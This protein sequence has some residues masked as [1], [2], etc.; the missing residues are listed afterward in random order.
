MPISERTIK[1]L[2]A[3]SQ[4]RCAN[5]DCR[6]P[7][8]IGAAVLGE[9][10]HIRARRKNGP[11]YD[12]ALTEEQKNSASNLVLLCPTCHSLV[13][14]DH[15]NAFSVEW[16]EQIKQEHE[17]GAPV[18]LPSRVA[19]LA[20]LMFNKSNSIKRQ[21][22]IPKTRVSSA[23]DTG[24]IAVSI[25]GDN[26]APINVKV[27]GPRNTGRGYRGNSLGAD[28]NLCG[29]IDY[30]VDLYSKYMSV[31]GEDE[32]SLKGRIGRAIKN[33]FRLKTRTRNDLPA[34]RFPDLVLFI[35]EKLAKTPV[36][37]KH[38]VNGTR[39]CSSFDEWRTTTR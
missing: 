14:K 16:L 31:T 4:N 3:K 35:Q 28:A 13:D 33:K 10:C 8:V 23:A 38:C 36:G 15:G 26:H 24:G 6:E 37:R 1:S 12:S 19:E 11:R 21:T 39:L 29:Y 17:S 9:I 27:S 20:S 34:E 25:G 2:F 30:L 22:S 7:L 5:P 18:E 32:H